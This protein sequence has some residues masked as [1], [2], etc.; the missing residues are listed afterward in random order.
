MLRQIICEYC[1]LDFEVIDAPE[2]GKIFCPNCAS[3]IDLNRA[4][5]IEAIGR[6]KLMKLLGQGG[7]G[8]VYSAVDPEGHVYALKVMI[9][10]SLESPD[11]IERFER[12]MTIMSGLNHP[13]IVRVIDRGAATSFK[14]FVME[15]VEGATLR[16]VIRGGGLTEARILEIVIGILRALGHAHA[17]GIIHRDIKP[18]NIMFDLRENVK[19]TDFGLARKFGSASDQQSLTATNAFMG[20]ENYMSPEQRI[21]PKSVTHKTDIYAVGVVLYEMLTGGLLPMGIFQPPSCYK[22][23]HHYWDTLT[24]RMLD[25]NPD[26]RPDNCNAIIDELERFQQHKA[27]AADGN[28]SAKSKP[29]PA[30]ERLPEQFPLS[31]SFDGF[32]QAENDRAKQRLKQFIDE[33]GAAFQAGNFE[34]AL[35]LFE[36]S[37]AVITEP[38]GRSNVLEW[39]RL[40]RE[41][42]QA[43]KDRHK[44][45]YMCPDCLKPFL[46][47][48][49]GGMPESLACPL[50]R[51]LLR[52]DPVRK[53]LRKHSA[54]IKKTPPSTDNPVTTPEK[55][56]S[57]LGNSWYQV[58]FLVLVGASLIDWFY[59]ELFEEGIGW[60]FRGKLSSMLDISVGKIILA[61]RFIMHL[62]VLITVIRL[63][64][65][66][67]GF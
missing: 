35:P 33:A 38:D 67:S 37:L 46:W 6:Y 58:A 16:Q 64:Y 30:E 52:F 12:E 31:P 43:A 34:A 41:K 3:E 8:Q 55:K 36:A 49:P 20:T 7:M 21:N 59:P 1:G 24:F 10:E 5:K 45:T 18:E 9:Q 17:H 32:V 26:M 63:A 65:I 60:L 25:L 27:E 22:P 4:Q 54:D 23:I 66:L 39:M 14:Y 11:L 61:V 56:A 47:S 57:A 44:P 15:L 50:C 40:C 48:E 2:S 28:G 29:A 19:V 13:N 51:C 53:Q 42:I 62:A